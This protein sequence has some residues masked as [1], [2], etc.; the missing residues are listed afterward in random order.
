MSILKIKT[1]AT[2]ANL[3][4]G[5]DVLGMCLHDPFDEMEIALLNEKSD[6]QKCGR[7]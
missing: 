1:P 5:F 3:V 7:L 2:V 4:C 6:C